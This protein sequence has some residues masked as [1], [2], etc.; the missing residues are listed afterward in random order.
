MWTH[1]SMSEDPR[2]GVDLHQLHN[3]TVYCLYA[4][5][6]GKQVVCRTTHFH[7]QKKAVRQSLRLNNKYDKKQ[8]G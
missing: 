6:Q 3:L 2:S 5:F 4:R 1:A 8:I 7:S